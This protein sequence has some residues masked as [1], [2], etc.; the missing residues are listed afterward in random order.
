[1]GSQGI[2]P[3]E[4]IGK[5][6]T[7]SNV[8]QHP[9]LCPFLVSQNV[10]KLRSHPKESAHRGIRT[11]NILILNQTPLPIGLYG[12]GDCWNLHPVTIGSQPICS[13]RCIQPQ[14]SDQFAIASAE[15]SFTVT[16]RAN[17]ITL[18]DFRNHHLPRTLHN[19]CRRIDYLLCSRPVIQVQYI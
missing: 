16:I 17:H 7:A 10:V 19:E 6:V 4:R 1:M 14:L 18:H 8:S 9:T 15:C 5:R 2:E 11:P 12:R 13:L 3:C